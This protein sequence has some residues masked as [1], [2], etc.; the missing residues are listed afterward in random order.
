M[1][2]AARV[3]RREVLVRTGAAAAFASLVRCGR[4]LGTG[5]QGTLV[6]PGRFLVPETGKM[7]FVLCLFD[8]DGDTSR[9]MPMDFF[10]HGLAQHPKEPRRAVIFEKKGPGCCEVDLVAGRVTRPITTPKERAFYGH[11][12][13]SRDG[14][15]LFATENRLETKTGLVCVRDGKTYAE[16]GEF[17]TYGKS[18]HDCHLIDE[19]RTLAIT[20]GG[21]VMGDAALDAAPSV[22]FVDAR[23]TKLL[24]RLTFDN[25]RINAGHL[26]LTRGRDLVAVSAPREGLPPSELGGVTIR[27]GSGPFVTMRDPEDVISRMAGE[28]LSLCFVEERAIVGVTNP[29]GNIVTFWDMKEKRFLKK[30]DL[31]APRGLAKT[32]DGAHLVLSYGAGSLTL[33]SP[34]TLEP[35]TEHRVAKSELSGSHVFTLDLA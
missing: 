16:I 13:F 17:P 26:A 29:D 2:E 1:S 5:R 23:S 18:P 10:G 7:S 34:D 6:G 12:A 3:T 19:G 14:A 4:G 9:T 20:N 33:L 8:L 15:I 31:P 35:V 28:S 30:L 21:G 25:P 11:G 22:T 32:L 24:E 27:T